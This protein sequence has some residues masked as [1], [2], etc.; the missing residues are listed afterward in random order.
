M[1]QHYIQNKTIVD[2]K[3]IHKP[4]V[5]Y[6]ADGQ[7]SSYTTVMTKEDFIKAYVKFILIPNIKNGQKF[8]G[9]KF[10]GENITDDYLE[11]KLVESYMSG[12]FEN[13][14]LFKLI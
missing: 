6:T 14:N 2:D 5:E 13:Y 9:T 1:G 3:G 4:C 11:N 12:N 8:D 10:L 7:C